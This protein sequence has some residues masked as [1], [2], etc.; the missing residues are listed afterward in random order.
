[1][2][3]LYHNTKFLFFKNFLKKIILIIGN[4]L[5]LKCKV[6]GNCYIDRSNHNS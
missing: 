4:I 1:M 5:N 2:M 6:N 3:C